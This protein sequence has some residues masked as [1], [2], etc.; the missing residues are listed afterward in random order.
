[1]LVASPVVHFFILNVSATLASFSSY[2]GVNVNLS[3]FVAISIHICICVFLFLGILVYIS[4]NLFNFELNCVQ[5]SSFS[6]C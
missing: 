3:T 1:M 4:T 6:D 2:P 5:V